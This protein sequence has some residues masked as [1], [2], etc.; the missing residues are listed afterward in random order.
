MP[1][2]VSGL[3]RRS[4][5]A[6]AAASFA[7]PAFSQ[8]LTPVEISQAILIANYTPVYLAQQRGLFAEQGLNVSISTAGGI[9]TVVPII[10]SKRAQFA[11]SG[12]A[13]AVNATLG[14]GATKCI[15]NIAGGSSLL[16]LARPGTSIRSLEDF[17]GKTIATLR[18][19]SN[20]NATPKYALTQ[21][22]KLNL[23]DSKIDF[24][25]LPPGAQVGAV[26]DGRA[27]LAVVFEWDASIGVTQ[28]GL[29]VV[30]GF[31]D[32]IGPNSSSAI[33]AT[34]EYLDAN[35][36][37]AQKLVNAI[38]KAM[39]IIHTEPEAYETASAIAFPAVPK[40]A[41]ALGSKRLLAM[42]SVVPRNP[43]ITKTS[44][45]RV[46]TMELGTGLKQSLPFEQMV[47]N[48][49]AEKATEA[50]GLKT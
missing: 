18:F 26:K 2:N 17:K 15:A 36:E 13:P 4:L 47:D 21:L 12:T 7:A 6:G 24:L 30:Y 38:A 42:H 46:M 22:A 8:S 27:D 1:Q 11:L 29:E 5:L 14:G 33:F 44:W 34:Q 49:F 23:A 39:K 50:Y 35:K 28:F 3:S 31:A 16:V 20:T 10:L 41:I 37:T 40:D 25:E 48:S 43:I 19:P 9:A 32:V 45:D